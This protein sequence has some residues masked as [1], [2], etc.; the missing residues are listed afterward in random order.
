[1]NVSRCRGRTHRHHAGPNVH[2][3]AIFAVQGA[4]GDHDREVV[5]HGEFEE[6]E[7]SCALRVASV[8]SLRPYRRRVPL[9]RL[10]S[11]NM[12]LGRDL[13]TL[14]S[15][16][17]GH[18]MSSPGVHFQVVTWRVHWSRLCDKSCRGS[19]CDTSIRRWPQTA[20]AMSAGRPRVGSRL[21]TPRIATLDGGVP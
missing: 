18:L 7:W 8:M 13:S 12:I 19:K 21:V 11:A 3:G 1:M 6:R 16:L 20:S 9:G 2:C 14:E 10:R 15:S 17:G 5:D 4:C